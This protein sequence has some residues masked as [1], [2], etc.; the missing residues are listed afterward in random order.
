MEDFY[1]K[2]GPRVDYGGK[3]SIV[4][5]PGVTRVIHEAKV[6]G[7]ARVSWYPISAS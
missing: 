3:W 4:A 5:P 6:R 7:G 2:W 1:E